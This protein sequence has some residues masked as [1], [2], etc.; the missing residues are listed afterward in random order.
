MFKTARKRF[1]VLVCYWIVGFV[2]THIPLRSAGAVVVTN[3]DKVVHFLLYGG[4]AFV[5]ATWLGT[6]RQ[7]VSTVVLTW[8]ICCAYAVLDEGLQAFIPNRDPSLGDWIADTLG[9]LVGC[10]CYGLLAERMASRDE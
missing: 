2:L 4:L 9:S 7:T 1:L 8:L 10:L 3:L 6:R 5:M